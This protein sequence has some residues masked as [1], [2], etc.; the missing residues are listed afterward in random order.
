MSAADLDCS[1]PVVAWS[2]DA[3]KD[4]RLSTESS[5]I[6]ESD[7]AAPRTPP[8]LGRWRGGSVGVSGALIAARR[9][10]VWLRSVLLRRNAASLHEYDQEWLDSRIS[11]SGLQVQA[12]PAGEDSLSSQSAFAVRA[13]PAPF[14]VAAATPMPKVHYLLCVCLF[15]ELFV[16]RDGRLAGVII[17]DD[18]GDGRRVSRERL[19]TASGEGRDDIH[20]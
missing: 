16:T 2:A 17:K 8:F 13:D 18:L 11:F 6:G 9:G 5:H 19:L 10:A 3:D 15:S 4:E 20:V 14:L 7:G 1:G 12:Q